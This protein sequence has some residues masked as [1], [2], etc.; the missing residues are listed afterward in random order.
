MGIRDRINALLGG[1]PVGGYAPDKETGKDG[2]TLDEELAI[3][4]LGSDIAAEKSTA[5]DRMTDTDSSGGR[6]DHY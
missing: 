4:D 6:S 2:D 1:G 5:F 3:K